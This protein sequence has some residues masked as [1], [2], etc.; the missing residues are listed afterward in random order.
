MPNS[1]NH[2]TNDSDFEVLLEYV[3][4]SRGFDFTG[5]K[6]FGLARRVSKRMQMVNIAVCRDYLNYLDE[7]P[8]EINYLLNALLINVTSFFRDRPAWDYVQREIIPD[9]LSHKAAAETI[10]V[11]SAGC[12][13][14]EEAYTIAIVLAEVLGIDAFRERVRIYATDVDEGALSQARQATYPEKDLTALSPGQLEQ[15]FHR[16]DRRLTVNQDLQGC[17]VFSHHDLLQAAPVSQIDL[18]VCRNTLMYFNAEAQERILTHFYVALQDR[19]VLFLG[20]PETLP[21]HL[22]IFA[23]RHLSHRVF[24]KPSYPNLHNR[25]FREPLPNRRPQ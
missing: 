12:A 3:K 18:L 4:R 25:E 10:R 23:P 19:G 5:Y 9:I 1:A 16:I 21:T 22:S 2:L 14:G 7:H 20:K 17:V 11:W 24:V 15:C 6:R 13:S 8:E